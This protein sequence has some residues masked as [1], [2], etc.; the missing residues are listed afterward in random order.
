[1]TS[2]SEGRFESEIDLPAGEYRLE[3]ITSGG[4]FERRVTLPPSETGG[5]LDLGD[6]V[7]RAAH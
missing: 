3:V 4:L 2:E 7:L 5:D 6:V 1:M